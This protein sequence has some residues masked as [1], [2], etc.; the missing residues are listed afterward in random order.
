MTTTAQARAAITAQNDAALLQLQLDQAHVKLATVQA[1]NRRLRRM[2]QNGKQGRLLHRA[3]ADARQIVG[4][5]AAGYSVTRR[6]ALSYGMSIRRW[7]WAIALLKLARVLDSQLAV[8]DAFVLDDVADCLQ[9]IDH[10]VKVVEAGGI[11]RLIVRLPRGA[12]RTSKR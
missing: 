7:Q 8:A 1:E 3:A 9:A 2:T 11:E 12:V 4:W 6:N 10:A 5:R